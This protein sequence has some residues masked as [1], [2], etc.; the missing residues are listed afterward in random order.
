MLANKI[1]NGTNWRT[2]K[3]MKGTPIQVRIDGNHFKSRLKKQLHH[4]THNEWVEKDSRY[5]WKRLQQLSK[6]MSKK[7]ELTRNTQEADQQK[8]IK[9]LKQYICFHHEGAHEHFHD[10]LDPKKELQVS[11]FTEYFN[12]CFKLNISKK[13][14]A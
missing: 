8:Y 5:A 13:I 11:S 6:N 7:A 10:K 3:V 2:C 4:N 14:P 12:P 9:M 1:H